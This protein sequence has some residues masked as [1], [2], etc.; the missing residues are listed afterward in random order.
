MKANEV[1]VGEGVIS[2]M[3]Q[4]NFGKPGTEP[5]MQFDPVEVQA[6]VIDEIVRD[7]TGLVNQYQQARPDLLSYPNKYKTELDKFLE[8][9]RKI[10]AFEISRKN[11]FVLQKTD[12][13]SVK[14]YI[15]KIKA[16]YDVG[17][18]TGTSHA[19]PK[20]PVNSPAPSQLQ[21]GVAFPKN[22][23]TPNISVTDD[24]GHTYTYTFPTTGGTQGEWSYNGAPITRPED[25]QTLNKLHLNATKPAAATP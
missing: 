5:G 13:A 12:P 23:G 1:I 25:I 16:A 19:L 6:G 18:R 24:N 8:T 11:N 17:T 21:T 22:T 20:P 3:I 10:P 2:R 9:S 14:Q 4:R 7:W 15:T